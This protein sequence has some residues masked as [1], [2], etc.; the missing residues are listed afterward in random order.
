MKAEIMVETDENAIPV[1]EIAVDLDDP[2]LYINREL[3]LLEFQRRV[4]EDVMD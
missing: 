3:S 2:K 1:K 4:L